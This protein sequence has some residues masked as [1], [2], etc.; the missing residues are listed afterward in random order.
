METQSEDARYDQL[1]LHSHRDVR[2]VP[3]SAELR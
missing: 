3:I 1:C 2:D